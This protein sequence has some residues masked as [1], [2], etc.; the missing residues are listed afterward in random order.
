MTLHDFAARTRLATRTRF[1]VCIFLFA[2]SL[3][4]AAPS[5]QAAAKPA[6][7]GEPVTGA[8]AAAGAMPEPRFDHRRALA[9]LSE[10]AGDAYEGRKSGTTGGARMEEF[11]ACEF[12]RAGLLPAGEAGSFFQRVPMLATEVRAASMELLDS[13]YGNVPLLYGN[14]FDPVTN[15][16]SGNVTA[17][18]IVVGHGLSDAAREWDDYGDFDVRGKVVLIFRGAPANGFDWDL[19]TTRDSTLHAAVARG[20]AAVLYVQESRPVHG[21]AVHAGSYFPTIPVAYVGHRVADLLFMETGRE[22]AKYETAIA[23]KPDPFATGKRIRIAFEVERVP[24]GLA[25]NA[26]AMI[27]GGDPRL[28]DE[29]VL[30][31]G[32]MD[33]VGMDALGRVFNGADDNASGASVVLEL[34]RAFAGGDR[35]R[36]TLVFATFAGEEQGLLGAEAFAAHPPIDL[37]RAVMMVNFDMAGH[38]SGKTGLGGGEQYPW[39]LRAFREALDPGVLDS[40]NL[41]RAWGGD[42]SDHAPFRN[43]GVPT[44]NLWSDGEHKFYHCLDDEFAWIDTLAV[45]GVGRAAERWIRFLADWP[46]PLACG[47]R[48]GRALLNT[49]YQVDFTGANARGRQH[50]EGDADLPSAPDVIAASTQWFD[51]GEFA[52]PTFLA[53]IARQDEGDARLIDGL[54]RVRGAAREWKHG[55]LIGLRDPQEIPPAYRPLLRAL[56]VSLLDGTSA[57]ST[58]IVSDSLASFA[59]EGALFLVRPD[60]AWVSGLPAEG[61]ALVRI[62]PARGEQIPDPQAYP[63]KRFFFLVSLDGPMPPAELASLLGRLGWDRVHLDL[64]PWMLASGE[65][66]VWAF[67]E[68]LLA[69]GNIEGRHLRAMLGGNLDR[70]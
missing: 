34:A 66:P 63:R 23:S 70:M 8:A 40:L 51:G 25:R 42:G 39:I 5:A 17:E 55:R 47:H 21:G 36:R 7:A 33:H 68:E 59:R 4:A 28:R 6:V 27:P 58:D 2:V 31:G 48:A 62:F 14:D 30:I 56:H 60:T 20:A 61:K 32:H 45:Q 44:S 11:A 1:P 35:P 26:V 50:G 38:G 69:T 43:T 15:S 65:E 46:Q 24:D 16:G 9:M 19:E 52:S 54:P 29:I 3:C 18:V 13:P 64:T 10:I 53:G 49:A 41:T 37:D 67:L 57:T 22:R 12:E